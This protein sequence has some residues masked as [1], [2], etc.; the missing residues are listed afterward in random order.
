MAVVGDNGHLAEEVGKGFSF[1]VSNTSICRG[2][3]GGVN[4]E[5]LLLQFKAPAHCL[6]REGQRTI[7]HLLMQVAQQTA[8][9][10]QLLQPPAPSP[11]HFSQHTAHTAAHTAHA[12]RVQVAQQDGQEELQ[13]HKHA[14]EDGDDEVDGHPGRGL[15]QAGR[16]WQEVAAGF[17]WMLMEVAVEEH[18][19][20]PG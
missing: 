15:L 18:M 2:E 9:K 13:Q 20:D 4:F 11:A 19:A 12:H 14:D 16:G 1:A 8:R 6:S 3:A 7:P 17:V 5:W 10:L